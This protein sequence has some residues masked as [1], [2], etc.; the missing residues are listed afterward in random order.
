LRTEQTMS[1]STSG[2]SVIS[3]QFRGKWGLMGKGGNAD[4]EHQ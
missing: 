1:T 3:G 4:N 2:W